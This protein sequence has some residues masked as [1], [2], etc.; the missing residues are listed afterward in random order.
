MAEAPLNGL[1]V[2][3]MGSL[4]AGPFCGQVLGDFGA[5]VIKLEDPKAGDP[6]RQ[7]GRTK[8]KG[9][10]PWWPVIGRNKTSVTLDLRA[11]EGREVARALID[12]AD[13]VVENFRPG[14][15]EKWGMG[16]ADLAKT[17]PGLVMA[18]VS[19]FGQTGPYS[20]RA[21]YAL[22]G[23]AMGG[24]RHIT[25]EADRPP[26]RA[27]ISIGDSLA[28]LNAA[29]GV[30]MA[31]HAR[32]RTGRGQVVDAAIYESVLTVMENL[33]TEYD[34]SGYVRERSGA[35]LPGIAP[36][37]VYP[38]RSGELI[39]IGANQDTLFKR[40]C[41]AM[42]RPE[43]A[44]DERYRDHAARGVNQTQLDATIGGWTVEHDIEHLL[45]LLEDAG[46]AVGRV[47]R[48][49]DMLKDPQ[50]A[51]RESIVEVA[52]PVFGTVKMQNAFPRLSETPGGVRWPGPA[53]GQH[54]DA[55]LRDVA[56]LSDETIAGLRAKGVI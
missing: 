10:S 21:G 36:S 28:G 5:E 6:M 4:I 43:L 20:H 25:G 32:R 16:Y 30:M 49:P 7:W 52:H 2:V 33:I 12:T 50:F 27:G 34:L 3:E 13:V 31:L 23:E 56:K 11:P 51:A 18:R 19:G 15:L 1:R 8:P 46:L 38:T 39:L 55:V 48:A 29:L 17:N 22:I 24:L 47:Y 53:L 14:T 45:P 42:G 41:D 44:T 54:T 26:A 9:H 37:N 35:I 40:L